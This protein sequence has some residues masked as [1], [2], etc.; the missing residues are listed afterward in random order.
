MPFTGDTKCKILFWQKAFQVVHLT[1]SVV[2]YRPKVT[3]YFFP[4][5]SK[6]FLKYFNNIERIQFV[7][8]TETEFV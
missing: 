5:N 3:S 2:I 4:E 6:L 7:S 1:K 8:L